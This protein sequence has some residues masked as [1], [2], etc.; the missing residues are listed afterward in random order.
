MEG[1]L[2]RDRRSSNGSQERIEEGAVPEQ[3]SRLWHCPQGPQLCPPG[4]SWLLIAIVMTFF[5]LRCR[6]M[7]RHPSIM[8]ICPA[9]LPVCV[10]GVS[11]APRMTEASRRP[12]RPRFA[13]YRQCSLNMAPVQGPLAEMLLS[14]IS[15]TASADGTRTSCAARRSE[16]ERELS[17]HWWGEDI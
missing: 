13:R 14:S 2:Y 10:I 1:A 4:A 15:S 3:V 17:M 5:F 9:D 8:T 11:S 12:L 6:P 16:G 7:G